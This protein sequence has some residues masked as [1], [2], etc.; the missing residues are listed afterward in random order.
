MPKIELAW[1]KWR[2]VMSHGP[3]MWQYGRFLTDVVKNIRD[4]ER[5]LADRHRLSNSEHYRGIEGKRVSRIPAVKLDSAIIAAHR[6]ARAWAAEFQEL[7][8]IRQ[9]WFGDTIAEE[10]LYEEL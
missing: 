9:R 3:G 5:E 4:L 6:R 10:V 8:E 1:W 2:Q 7:Q